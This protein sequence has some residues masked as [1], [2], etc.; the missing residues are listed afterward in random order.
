MWIC[1]TLHHII[2]NTVQ[3][4]DNFKDIE[5]QYP[6]TQICFLL[7]EWEIKGILFFPLVFHLSLVWEQSPVSQLIVSGQQPD[8]KQTQRQTEQRLHGPLWASLAD[9]VEER[10][11]LLRVSSVSSSINC[12]VF[13]NQCCCSI[14]PHLLQS[15]TLFRLII[16]LI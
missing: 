15:Q 3:W 9:S 7:P 12:S 5:Y 2:K 11:R 10:C 16:R 13:I 6:W 14:R 8:E 4:R 1:K